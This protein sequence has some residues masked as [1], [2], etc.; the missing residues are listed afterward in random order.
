MV[1][2]FSPEAAQ[3][4][5]DWI[6]ARWDSGMTVYATNYLSSLKITPKNRSMVRLNGS[7]VEVQRGRHWDSI[8]GCKI[9]AN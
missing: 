1:K 9:T 2:P 4:I 5:W 3:V 7:H 8:I 6:N